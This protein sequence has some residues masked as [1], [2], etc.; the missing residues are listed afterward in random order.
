MVRIF[1]P[2]AK[3]FKLFSNFDFETQNVVN[4]F[5]K[6]SISVY[7]DENFN[8]SRQS[9]NGTQIISMI[10]SDNSFSSSILSDEDKENYL[11]GKNNSYKIFYLR[12]MVFKNI[13]SDSVDDLS[14]VFVLSM[15]KVFN[16]SKTKYYPITC[17]DK[18]QFYTTYKSVIYILESD[19]INNSDSKIFFSLVGDF[20]VI[21]KYPLSISVTNSNYSSINQSSTPT[22]KIISSVTNSTQYFNVVNYEFQNSGYSD[23]TEFSFIDF[24]MPS[25]PSLF[26][27][28]SNILV[29]STNKIFIKLSFDQ[30]L[31]SS[32]LKYFGVTFKKTDTGYNPNIDSYYS[33]SFRNKFGKLYRKDG[34][35]VVNNSTTGYYNVIFNVKNLNFSTEYVDY[36]LIEIN[37]I[38]SSMVNSYE[39]TFL[40]FLTTDFSSFSFRALS[41][42][43]DNYITTNDPFLDKIEI[44]NLTYN[45]PLISIMGVGK[46]NS[47]INVY[48]DLSFFI[49]TKNYES[50]FPENI[51]LSVNGNDVL[52]NDLKINDLI[53]TIS[54]PES[55]E[56]ILII[57]SQEI[58]LIDTNDKQWYSYQ[59]IFIKNPAFLQS[60]KR[61]LFKDKF[62][63]KKS[64]K[65]ISINGNKFFCNESKQY[66]FI[67]EDIDGLIISINLNKILFSKIFINLSSD[68]DVILNYDNNRVRY[69]GNNPIIVDF[70]PENSEIYLR[71][72]SK[73]KLDKIMV[74]KWKYI[75]SKI[76]IM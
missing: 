1:Y 16:D 40:S 52:I 28:A 59:G 64:N 61:I 33:I 74:K 25:F 17:I 67:D 14:S 47:L 8:Y 31:T 34:C 69:S 58:K 51:Y 24:V 71:S 7:D 42:N 26:S 4:N 63:F 72:D 70:I 11:I 60:F 62:V 43:V 45:Q 13:I 5:P 48:P 38:N 19:F 18:N 6:Y 2:V 44:D 54:G 75:L 30:G 55:V 68:S 21:L 66:L 35:T 39:I 46:A 22:T 12:I 65:F 57:A 23:D 27:T 10:P 29:T 37:T 41:N 15:T 56:K 36:V 32:T 20:N 50:Y 9:Y 3:T 76:L 49:K 53:E 73:I